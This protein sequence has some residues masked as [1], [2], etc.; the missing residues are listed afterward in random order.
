MAQNKGM[1]FSS[2]LF[3]I[4]LEITIEKFKKINTN[5]VIL[6]KCSRRLAYA[7]D[8]MITG[9]TKVDIE[10]HVERKVPKYENHKLRERKVKTLT[11][12]WRDHRRTGTYKHT[13]TVSRYFDWHG[14]LS[15]SKESKCLWTHDK[16]GATRGSGSLVLNGTVDGGPIGQLSRGSR[17]L[18]QSLAGMLETEGRFL[19]CVIFLWCRRTS[20]EHTVEQHYTV[21]FCFKL[22]N[23]LNW[24]LGMM[25]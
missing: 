20:M 7:D 3:N 10:D 4:A 1:Q 19:W 12:N 11:R 6:I 21:K 9:R 16:D 18:V 8:L 15:Q 24:L 5:G 22:L 13:E 23:S 25:P 2:L 17:T 14:S